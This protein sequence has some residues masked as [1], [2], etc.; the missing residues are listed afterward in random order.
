MWGWLGKDSRP[1]KD[2]Q[3]DAKK[4]SNGWTEEELM[5]QYFSNNDDN[6]DDD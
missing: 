5:W 1:Q 6:D 3:K 2:T 4:G